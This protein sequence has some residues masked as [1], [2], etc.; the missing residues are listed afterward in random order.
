MRR[1]LVS[2]ATAAALAV[3][4]VPA[5]FASDPVPAMGDTV[6]AP[7]PSDPAPE[8]TATPGP[9]DGQVVED[10]TFVSGGELPAQAPGTGSTPAAPGVTPP[11]TDAPAV[12]QA[13]GTTTQLPLLLIAA[14]A[15]VAILVSPVRRAQAASRGHRRA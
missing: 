11:P 4:V 15:L 12:V 9:W 3:A 1:L 14:S 8:A 5:A 13:T 7:G 10:P 6:I 2:L